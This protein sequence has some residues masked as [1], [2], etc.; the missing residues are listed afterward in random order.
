MPPVLDPSRSKVDGLAF[1]GL[2]LTR[3]SEQGH[4]ESQTHQTAFDWNDVLDRDYQYIFSTNDDGW[5]VGGGEPGPPRSYKLAAPDS[6][7]VE[8]LRIGTYRPEWGG[9]AVQ[10]VIQAI[11]AGHILI[12]QIEVLPTAVVANGD[13]PPELEIRFDMEPNTTRLLPQRPKD[14]AVTAAT[15]TAAG[16]NNEY[17]YVGDVEEVDQVKPTTENEEDDPLPVN[18]QLR[19]LHNQLFQYFSYPS[20]FC[21][22]AFHSTILRKAEFRSPQHR[23]EYFSKCDRAIQGWRQRGPQPLV[24]PC[25]DDLERQNIQVIRG[26]TYSPEFQSGLWLFTD[27]NTITHHFAPNFLPPYTGAKR[28]LILQA[29]SNEWDEQTLKWIPCHVPIVT[30]NETAEEEEEDD[31][32]EEETINILVEA[33][34]VD[35]NILVEA[36]NVDAPDDEQRG[37]LTIAESRSMHTPY[38][39]LSQED[40]PAQR[41]PRTGNGNCPVSRDIDEIVLLARTAQS[42]EE[43]GRMEHVSTMMHTPLT[44]QEER[45]DEVEEG[46]EIEE[47]KMEHP[48]EYHHQASSEAGQAEAS[49]AS[50]DEI[51]ALVP[52][53]SVDP[54]ILVTVSST[55]PVACDEMEDTESS[56]LQPLSKDALKGSADEAPEAESPKIPKIYSEY[57]DSPQHE[58][59]ETPYTWVSGDHPSEE[60]SSPPMS[61]KS[62][63]ER[64]QLGK[65]ALQPESGHISISDKES[66]VTPATA[67]SIDCSDTKNFTPEKEKNDMTQKSSVSNAENHE[68]VQ[69]QQE[70]EESQAM[71]FPVEEIDEPPIAPEEPA[72][73][74]Q[75]EDTKHNEQTL[76]T[77]HPFPL[78]Q[79]Q[80]EEISSVVGASRELL[81][82]TA[83]K[84]NPGPQDETIDILRISTAQDTSKASP[85]N[86]HE[87]LFQERFANSLDSGFLEFK[88]AKENSPSESILDKQDVDGPKNDDGEDAFEDPSM[89]SVDSDN[90][91]FT[92]ALEE[93]ENFVSNFASSPKDDVTITGERSERKED[94]GKQLSND[95]A[96]NAG[97]SKQ[98]VEKTIECVSAMPNMDEMATILE[99][100]D[101]ENSTAGEPPALDSI[102]SDPIVKLKTFDDVQVQKSCS[103][104]ADLVQFSHDENYLSPPSSKRHADVVQTESHHSERSLRSTMSSEEWEKAHMHLFAQFGTVRS[105]AESPTAAPGEVNLRDLLEKTTKAEEKKDEED[106]AD[107][108]SDYVQRQQTACGDCGVG[109]IFDVFLNRS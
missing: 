79:S 24:P 103:A 50:H 82:P 47:K 5:L 104:T 94:M 53:D 57:E 18:W 87:E 59:S 83:M 63:E 48:R 44:S 81:L 11:Q 25:F 107:V 43:H 31:D 37:G 22:G 80:Y 86:A 85:S 13:V 99:V 6:A 96:G 58:V 40:E 56:P 74:V 77:D 9:L 15:M 66:P 88:D 28:R 38:M 98:T 1:L 60:E 49:S 84:E 34:N 89:H 45:W 78:A 30:K 26:E 32:E 69:E 106:G 39:I 51:E 2:S 33:E 36:E 92:D 108:M 52:T 93:V 16:P 90:V 68:P 35:I 70:E 27:R 20:R 101:E 65:K 12:P 42:M 19:F 105:E 3:A 100:G 95:S 75:T 7:H 41:E 17:L 55:G 76:S 4:P 10:D 23:E 91:D 14:H 61:I 8:L 102:D 64:D 21:P 73:A 54:I 67:A 62:S 46:H 72:P 109:N 97:A 71:E 29:L